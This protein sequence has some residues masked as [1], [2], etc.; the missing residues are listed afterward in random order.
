MGCHKQ[1]E[2]D[3]AYGHNQLSDTTSNF[4]QLYFRRGKPQLPTALGALD[5]QHEIDHHHE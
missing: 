4:T 3:K 1:R 5:L 2:K